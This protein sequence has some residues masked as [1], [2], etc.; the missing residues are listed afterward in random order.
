MNWLASRTLGHYMLFYAKN[1]REAVKTTKSQQIS[2]YLWT[3]FSEKEHDGT[4]IY[5]TCHTM[6]LL[7]SPKKISKKPTGS[8]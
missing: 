2:K 1:Q 5:S 6:L 7:E 8:K 4:K 3:Q